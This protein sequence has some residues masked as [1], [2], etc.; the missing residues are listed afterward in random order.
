MVPEGDM[1]RVVSVNRNAAFPKTVPTRV[2][3][4]REAKIKG[5]HGE[6]N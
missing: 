5:G 1:V 2:R 3:G 4:V 6:S